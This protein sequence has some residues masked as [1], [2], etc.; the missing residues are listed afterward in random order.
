MNFEHQLW[1]MLALLVIIAAVAILPGQPLNQQRDQ[2]MHVGMLVVIR[3][4]LIL[5]ELILPPPVVI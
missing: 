1:G 3:A 4:A 2:Q 5:Y